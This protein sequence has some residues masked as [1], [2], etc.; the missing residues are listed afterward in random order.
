MMLT[1]P[2]GRSASLNQLGELQCRQRRRLGGLEDD[3]VARRQRRRD[4]PRGHQ[5]REIPRDDLPR[6][7]QRL[8]LFRRGT[9]I[10]ACRPSPRSRRSAPPR[11][12]YRHRA[13]SR[14]GFPAVHRFDDRKLAGALLKHA[15]DAVDVFAALSSRAV[16]TRPCHTPVAAAVTALSTSS[17]AADATSPAFLPL[18]G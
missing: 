11:A 7:A 9:R 15:G 3:G 14:I 10:P 18:P 1:T 5:Q 2:G 8:R 17:G 13:L 4:L 16:S 6:D 12:G